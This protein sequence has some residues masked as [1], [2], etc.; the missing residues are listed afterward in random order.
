MYLVGTQQGA[1]RA[2]ADGGFF[3]IVKGWRVALVEVEAGA[4]LYVKG[5][6]NSTA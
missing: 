3:G 6:A 2:Q 1:G 4:D 5:F